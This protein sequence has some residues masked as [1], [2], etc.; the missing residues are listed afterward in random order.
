M[1]PIIGDWLLNFRQ[2]IYAGSRFFALYFDPF[3]PEIRA[4][5]VTW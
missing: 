3:F 1:D 5:F 4:D 2:K